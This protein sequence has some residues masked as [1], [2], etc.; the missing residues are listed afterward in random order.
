VHSQTVLTPT[1]NKDLELIKPREYARHIPIEAKVEILH[2]LGRDSLL[3]QGFQDCV[4]V[5]C[6][7]GKMSAL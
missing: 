2:L 7:D 3:S 4:A 5:H 6:A 1:G